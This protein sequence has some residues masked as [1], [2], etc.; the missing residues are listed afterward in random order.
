VAKLGWLSHA[1]LVNLV[2]YYGTKRAKAYLDH[3]AYTDNSLSLKV[4]EMHA[5]TTSV[6]DW[7]H[8]GVLKL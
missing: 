5:T 6:L 3:E 7:F 8:K 1:L 2:Y 4:Q